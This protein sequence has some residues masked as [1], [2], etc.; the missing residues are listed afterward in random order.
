MC[1]HKCVGKPFPKWEGSAESVRTLGCDDLLCGPWR[2]SAVSVLRLL[3]LL[4]LFARLLLLFGYY[5]ALEALWRYINSWKKLA[6]LSS[7]TLIATGCVF[8]VVI[9]RL[10]SDDSVAEVL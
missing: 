4:L 6:P 5:G 7:K 1:L 9:F 8:A 2:G 3:L 10:M